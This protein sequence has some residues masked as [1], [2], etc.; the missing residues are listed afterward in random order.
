MYWREDFVET[1]KK[2]YR[3]GNDNEASDFKDSE[4]LLQDFLNRYTDPSSSEPMKN[5]AFIAW[6]YEKIKRFDIK[7]GANIYSWLYN[8][9]EAT[10]FS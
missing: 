3:Q 4:L 10:F 2:V 5:C 9:Q 8:D 7:T 6:S 1:M